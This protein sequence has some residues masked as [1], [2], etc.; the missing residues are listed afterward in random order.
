MCY[1]DVLENL[2]P[3]DSKLLRP[4]LAHPDLH[5]E[6]I[7]V[8]SEN[9]SEITAILDWSSAEVAPL[10]AQA[11]QPHIIDYEGPKLTG[12]E[13]PSMPTD[14]A[15]KSDE[16]K[17]SSTILYLEQNLVALY[18]KLISK[19]SP[20]MWRCFEYREMPQFTLLT[21]ARRLLEEGEG[22]YLAHFVELIESGSDIVALSDPEDRDSR[23][24]RAA[25]LADKDDILEYMETVQAGMDVMGR[26]PRT[27][28]DLFPE[29]GVVR[30]DQYEEAKRA[31]GQIKERVIEEFARSE[32]DRAGWHRSWPFND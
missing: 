11:R 4:S 14:L 30:H 13:R 12:L 15:G 28:G 21:I 23:A 1:L 5:A 3:R 17:F 7:F 10:L 26:I 27:M 16:E 6:N 22:P 18:R 25:L 8:D 31:L 32:E 20:G 24:R 19:R 29:Q 2:L 9:P